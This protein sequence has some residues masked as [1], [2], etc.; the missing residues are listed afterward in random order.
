MFYVNLSVPTG[1]FRK[2]N[3]YKMR[4]LLCLL[5]CALTLSLV[6]FV[7]CA[8]PA[9]LEPRQQPAVDTVPDGRV[10]LPQAKEDGPEKNKEYNNPLTTL[11]ADPYLYKRD[12]MY[13]FTGSYPLY[14]RID[15]T[16]ADSV[17]GISSAVPKTIWTKSD[18][19]HVWAPEIHYVMGKWVIYFAQAAGADR[20]WDIRC[21]ALV[22]KG[23]DPMHD[24]WEEPVQM[25]PAPG[26][27][28]PFR[29]WGFS[30]DMT[31]LQTRLDGESTDR[32]YAIWAQKESIPKANGSGWDQGNSFIYIGE[33]ET[34]TK[35]RSDMVELTRPQYDWE[36]HREKVNEGPSILKHNDKIY[37]VFSGSATGYEYCMG[38]MEL[39]AGKDPLDMSN[40]KK[41]DK[42]VFKTNSKLGIYGPGHNCFTEGDD[43]EPLCIL[44]FRNYKDIIGGNGN[45][46]Y[47]YN[48]HAYV[49]KITFDE[50]DFPVFS[51]TE[52][53]LFNVP[54]VNQ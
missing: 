15:L 17:N 5:C 45:S 29:E 1:N 53:E 12:G 51:L 4:K 24:E 7:G 11:R 49:M 32:W 22:C 9:P 35:L 31:I 39:T 19:H 41:Y 30:L 3:E 2:E 54:F 8:S 44:H 20:V 27:E 38:I 50:N 48:R 40:W 18:A 28:L 37:M 10:P 14:D 42:P 13:Y 6:G 33:L 16:C 47:D 34:P 23:Q 43:G 25:S 46:L 21:Y 52:D 36:L 26:N